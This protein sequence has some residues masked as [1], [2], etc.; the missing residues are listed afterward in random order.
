MSLEEVEQEGQL[1]LKDANCEPDGYIEN[2]V[3]W[4]LFWDFLHRT[5]TSRARSFAREI[6]RNARERNDPRAL[7]L[8]LASLGWAEIVDEQYA[9]ALTYGE[10]GE[11]VAILPLDRLWSIQVKAIALIGLRQ[12]SEGV[13]VLNEVKKQ[14]LR[15][16]W[17]YMLTGTQ[18]ML[19]LATIMQGS[20]A[21]GISELR[22]FIVDNERIG[23]QLIADWARI[24]L[25][26]VYLELLSGKEKPSLGVLAGNFIFLVRTLPFAAQMA[27]DLLSQ[28]W[29]NEQIEKST[30]T[31]ARISFGMGLACKLRKRTAEARMH[32]E[33]AQKIALPLRTT[34]L[35]AK[36]EAALAEL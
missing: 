27:F 1:A 26:E 5:D 22:R 18:L 4:V 7:G 33:R 21:R 17:R 19:S 36:I 3:P 24:Y 15:N 32:L 35:L 6:V 30:G 29:S 12:T 11:R 8:G 16:D 13:P 10:E 25:A 2:W 23:Y 9:D 20:F 28:A 14:F 34:T 31:A